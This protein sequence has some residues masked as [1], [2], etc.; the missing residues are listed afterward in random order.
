MDL[1]SE[2]DSHSQIAKGLAFS[3]RNEIDQAIDMFQMASL[4]GSAVANYYLGLIC[5]HPKQNRFLAKECIDYL[6]ASAEAGFVDASIAIAFLYHEGI[7]V[8]RNTEL[9]NQLMD[10]LETKLAPGETWFKFANFYINHFNLNQPDKQ[11]DYLNK[12]AEL[13][14]AKA[15][16]FA[17]ST[18][19]T[20][21]DDDDDAIQGLLQQ[22]KSLAEQGSD[23][24]QFM[25][26]RTLLNQYPKGSPEWSEAETWLKKSAKAGS[27]SANYFMGLAYQYGY[28]GDINMLNAYL[29]YNDAA[30]DFHD[31]AQLKVGY[32]N[33]VGQV[34]EQN[35]AIALSW[36]LLCSKMNNLVCTN[37][38]G[39][40]F[41]D[42]IV[43]DRDYELANIYFKHAAD[44]GS[45]IGIINYASMFWNGNGVEQSYEKANQLYQKGCDLKQG[46]ACLRLG[47]SYKKGNG[48]ESNINIANDFYKQSCDFGY[49]AGC[50]E[51]GFSYEN[52][53][54]FEASYV[55]AGKLYDKAC[56]IGLAMAC[57]NYGLLYFNGNGV[58]EDLDKAR[59]LFH[60]ACY[61]GHQKGCNMLLV[62]RD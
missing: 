9:S 25:Y 13:G 4:Q 14:N 11:L 49:G 2:T 27:P 8:E 44:S 60:K 38:L 20:A 1:F 40:Y 61:E 43:V 51:L 19:M 52:G 32:M 10:S 54:G 59:S 24:A 56:Q 62:M 21:I 31:E 3:N 57:T 34:V 5:H 48:F 41:R 50:N 35:P 42:G 30:M 28:F 15:E 12:S 26:A 47:L 23:A 39:V 17:L 22:L 29:A 7:G 37:N 6:F 33:G 53:M 36:Y 55:E 45:S 46:Q 58:E 16:L 18:A